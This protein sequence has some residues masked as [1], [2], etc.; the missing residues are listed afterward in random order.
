MSVYEPLQLMNWRE[1]AVESL[2]EA[3]SSGLG[4]FV[5]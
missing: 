2:K 3:T 4:L 1:N 5:C